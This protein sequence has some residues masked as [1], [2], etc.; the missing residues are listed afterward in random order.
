MLGLYI[1]IPLGLVMKAMPVPRFR[2]AFSLLCGLG[3]Q[4]FIF[5]E[6]IPLSKFGI[7]AIFPLAQVFVAYT[8][9]SLCPRKRVGWTVT[10]FSMGYLSLS[11]IIRMFVDYGG[12]TI[13]V[14]TVLMIQTVFLSTFAWDYQ[15]GATAEGRTKNKKAV[16]DLPSLL[17]FVSAGT[18]FTQSLAGPC[19]NFVD[20]SD[21]VWCRNDFA[22]I[23]AGSNVKACGRALLT[24]LAWTGVQLVLLK[25]R[26]LERMSDPEG[27]MQSAGIFMRV[28]KWHYLE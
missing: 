28:K 4:F 7:D 11:H 6:C 22:K 14:V 15:D 16:A 26:V 18:C 23:P 5:S 2:L 27:S 21:Y 25:F 13:T 1:S 24:A 20:F 9:V 3:I 19:S 8:I 12:W 17:E 10:M